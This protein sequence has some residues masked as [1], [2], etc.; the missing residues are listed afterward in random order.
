MKTDNSTACGILTGTIKQKW[1]KAIGMWSYWLKDRAKQ[2]QFDIYWEPGKHN[3]ADYPTKHHTGSHHAAV[4]PIY[5]YDKHKTPKTV[6]GC[7]EILD[8][9][10]STKQCVRS[11]GIRTHNKL[12]TCDPAGIPQRQHRACASNSI[13]RNETRTILRMHPF[14]YS[15]RKALTS[16]YSNLRRVLRTSLI[17]S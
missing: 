14:M 13:S 2:G 3:L 4:R 17:N 16:K 6:K 10:F 15:T 11:G 9:T 5:L 12:T 8:R 1:S 7:V